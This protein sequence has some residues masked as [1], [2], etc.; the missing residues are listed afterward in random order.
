M[1]NHIWTTLYRPENPNSS[2]KKPV[3]HHSQGPDPL[4][5]R[6]VTITT[7][8]EDTYTIECALRQFVLYSTISSDEQQQAKHGA[9]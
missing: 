9:S 1:T 2:L 8:H 6:L 7:D 4:C 3:L 5:N